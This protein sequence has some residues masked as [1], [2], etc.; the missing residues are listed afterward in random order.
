MCAA[1]CLISDEFYCLDME[2]KTFRTILPLLP[3]YLRDTE[4]LISDLQL[5]HDSDANFGAK[6]LLKSSLRGVAS[7]YRL[8]LIEELRDEN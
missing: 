7:T 4:E 6:K 8:S 3:K 2:G 1:G 5:V